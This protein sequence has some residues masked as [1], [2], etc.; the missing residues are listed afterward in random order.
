MCRLFSSIEV[1]LVLERALGLLAA[2]L[3]AIAQTIAISAEAAPEKSKPL[4]PEFL[5][6][7]IQNSDLGALRDKDPKRLVI[8]AFNPRPTALVEGLKRETISVIYSDAGQATV[9]YENLGGSMDD[10]VSSFRYVSILELEGEL[11]RLKQVKKQWICWAGRG[12]QDWSA[13]RCS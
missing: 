6:V 9:M 12:H 2:G 1:H 11:W 4:A 5:T 7:N 10:S 8:Q 13:Q 3:L